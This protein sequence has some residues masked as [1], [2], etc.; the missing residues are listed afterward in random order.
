MSRTRSA[1]GHGCARP[2]G[3]AG[4]AGSQQQRQHGEGERSAGQ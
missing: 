2:G 4:F 3:R 1:G